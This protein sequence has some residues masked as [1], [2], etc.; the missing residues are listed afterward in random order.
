MRFGKRGEKE[1][2]LIF[3]LFVLLIITVVIVAV[4]LNAIKQ[5]NEPGKYAKKTIDDAQWQLL[6]ADCQLE[7][8]RATDENGVIEFCSATK[9]L[10]STDTKAAPSRGE[11]GGNQFCT[12]KIPCFLVVN[13]CKEQYTADRCKQQLLGDEATYYK[14]DRLVTDVNSNLVTFTDG[15]GLKTDPQDL[16]S[17][18]N[19]KLRYDYSDLQT[20][21]AQQQAT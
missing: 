5:V 1:L 21:L 6:V 20:A 9:S 15:C 7:C 2:Q 11:Y 16:E 13:N 18:A 10:G 4:F 19:W 8:D 3:G 14:Y 17:K 12:T